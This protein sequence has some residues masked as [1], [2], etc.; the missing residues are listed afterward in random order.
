MPG[1]AALGGDW[2]TGALCRAPLGGVG[3]RWEEEREGAGPGQARGDP[4]S[5]GPVLSDALLSPS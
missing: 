5:G 4:R 3:G 1:A 2:W